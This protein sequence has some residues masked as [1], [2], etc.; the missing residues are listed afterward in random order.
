[1]FW[2]EHPDSTRENHSPSS[3]SGRPHE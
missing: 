3:F 2:Q 1:V